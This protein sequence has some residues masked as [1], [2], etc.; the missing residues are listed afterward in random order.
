MGKPIKIDADRDLSSLALDVQG[1]L[2]L[3]E[4]HLDH[5]IGDDEVAASRGVDY[6]QG[7]QLAIES[8]RE[9]AGYLF[10]A[11]DSI[12]TYGHK[13]SDHAEI[14][15]WGKLT[16]DQQGLIRELA[17]TIAEDDVSPGAATMAEQTPSI[18]RRLS[19]E[20][21]RQMYLDASPEKRE[22]LMTIARLL[23]ELTP[24]EEEG[25]SNV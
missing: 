9:I 20:E 3:V 18:D 16:A 11:L 4:D 8:A 6:L 5:V 2:T 17:G 21:W 1:V 25:C 23:S 13:G 12:E 10:C 19:H 24:T 15:G 7:L 14:E 22:R